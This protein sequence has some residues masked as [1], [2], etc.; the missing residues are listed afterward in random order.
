MIYSIDIKTLKDR[1]KT[2]LLRTPLI[3][4]KGLVYKVELCFPCG[5]AGLMGVAIFDGSYSV[6]PSTIGEFFIG[7]NTTIS[8]EDMYLKE[9]APYVFDI[10]TY[11]IDTKYAHNVQIRIGQVSKDVFMARFLPSVGYKYFTDM[12]QATQQ[13]QVQ[14]AELQKASILET[15]F[16]W[17][18]NETD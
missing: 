16:N 13:E 10:Y 12:L 15:P 1:F 9:S 14:Q 4:T 8:F 7:D 18:A 3:V 11:N 5:S 2:N 6:W 17:L